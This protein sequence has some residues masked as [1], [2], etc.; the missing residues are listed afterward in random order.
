M[1]LEI[2]VGLSAIG[3]AIGAGKKTVKKII[4]EN[5]FPAVRYSDGIYRISKKSVIEWFLL[6]ERR[7]GE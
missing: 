3:H 6:Q 7:R 1:S 5:G 4:K 2:L